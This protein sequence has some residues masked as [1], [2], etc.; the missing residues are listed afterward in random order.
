M[1]AAAPGFAICCLIAGAGAA[2][3]QNIYLPQNVYKW[4][5]GDNVTHYSAQPP[6]GMPAE[7]TNVRI[8]GTSRQSLQVRM[9]EQTAVSAAK[10]TR[11]RQEGEDAA[12]SRA[13]EQKND[14]IRGQNCAQAQQQ[15]KTY[16]EAHRLYRT[17]D[18]G[19]REYLTSDQIDVERIAANRRVQEWCD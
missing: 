12:E 5:D 17:L 9:N 18:N 11:L 6:L 7:R 10:N 4:V 16:N 19:E 2:L 1:K 13:N 14:K 3:A 15:Q 8:R